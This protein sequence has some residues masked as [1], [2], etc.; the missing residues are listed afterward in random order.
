MRLGSLGGNGWTEDGYSYSSMKE[1]TGYVVEELGG[2][3]ESG[4]ITAISQ[5]LSPLGMVINR[6]ATAFPAQPYSHQMP[7]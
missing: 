6:A 2:R 1:S 3:F 4:A 5:V 7:Q